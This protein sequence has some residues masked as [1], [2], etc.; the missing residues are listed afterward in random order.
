[1]AKRLKQGEYTTAKNTVAQVPAER[2]HPGAM[3]YFKEVGLM[4]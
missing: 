1:M 4:E 3:R 2:L